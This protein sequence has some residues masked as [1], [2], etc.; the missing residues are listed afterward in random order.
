VLRE[1]LVGTPPNLNPLTFVTGTA[2]GYIIDYEYLGGVEYL[3]NGTAAHYLFKSVTTNS[4]FTVWKFNLKTGAKWSDGSPITATDIITSEGPKFAFNP[5]YNFLGIAQIVKNEYAYND[6]MAVF[7]LNKSDSQL[8]NGFSLDGAGGTPFFPAKVINQYGAAY[9]ML[10]VPDAGP[11]YVA[12][13]T[14]GSPTMTLLRNPYFHTLGLP[15]PKICEVDIQFVETT[16]LTAERVAAGSVDLAPIVA[17]D[18]PALAAIPNVHILKETGEGAMTLE[19]NITKY[20]YNQTPFRQALVYG[21]NQS[22][23]IQEGF[24]GYGATAY[25]GQGMVQQLPGLRWYNPNQMTYSYDPAKAQSLLSS[26]GITKQSDGFLHYSNGTIASLTIWTDSDQTSDLIS[27]SVVQRNLQSLGF[28]VDLV[29][30]TAGDIVA[31]YSSNI[32]HIRDQIILFSGFVTNFGNAYVDALQAWNVQWLPT[33]S[34]IHWLYPPSA[35][36]QYNS[37]LSAFLSTVDPNLEQKYLY[38]IQALNA[39]DLGTVTLSYPDAVIAYST[40]RWINWPANSHWDE[41]GPLFMNIT[42]WTSLAPVSL[43]VQTTTSTTSF[44]TSGASS[45]TTPTVASPDY[46]A[47]IVAGVAVVMIIIAA[48][49]LALRRRR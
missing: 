48:A 24:S 45:T 20:P 15:E 13:F 38:N 10:N 18:A 43:P 11:F 16:S 3:L 30:V 35:D 9:P 46:T 17:T 14:A 6:S 40:A 34:N 44:T 32:N 36:D 33:Q 41:G 1:A 37:N 47:Y 2:A 4:N 29:T 25:N 39:Q 42:A 5:T 21:I 8:D 27:A 22:Q 23:I 31:D 49:V 26:I 12:N 28:K 19:Y 7:V